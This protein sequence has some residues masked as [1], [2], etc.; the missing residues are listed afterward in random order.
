V[1]SENPAKLAGFSSKSA[2]LAGLF[3]GLLCLLPGILAGLLALLAR[4]AAPVALLRLFL[5]IRTSARSIDRDRPRLPMTNGRSRRLV[6]A[7]AHHRSLIL[8]AR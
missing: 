3:A 8:R 7:S 2:F 5:G 6:R 1:R 4:F